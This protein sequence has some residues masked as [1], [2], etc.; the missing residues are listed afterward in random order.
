MGIRGYTSMPSLSEIA[1]RPG[2]IVVD[3]ASPVPILGV[4]TGFACVI[5]EFGKGF[6]YA[7]IPTEVTSAQDR[8]EKFGGWMATLGDQTA[9]GGLSTQYTYNGNGELSLRNKTFSRLAVL[10]VDQHVGHVAISRTLSTYGTIVSTMPAPFVLTPAGQLVLDFD[11]LGAPVTTTF[12]AAAA[13]RECANAEVYNLAFP[14]NEL[15]VKV[16]G[17]AR[18]TL[19][20]A[21]PYFVAPG[22]ATAEEVAAAI[23]D[24]LVGGSA[25]ATTGATKV[26]V[27]SDKKG[28]G[29]YI[30][31]EGGS[32]NAVLAFNTAAVQGTG[33]SNLLDITA[34]SMAE[35]ILVINTAIGV[36][37]LA[38]SD[39]GVYLKVRT[40]TAGGAPNGIINLG[41]GT[42]DMST[43]LG[44]D[45]IQHYGSA[46]GVGTTGT[47]PAGTIVSASISGNRFATL[48][49]VYFATTDATGTGVETGS[50]AIPVR[51]ANAAVYG[52]AVSTA[53]LINTIAA[54]DLDGDG[55][56]EVFTV[57]NAAD[58]TAWNPSVAY[59]TA[60]ATL[61]SRNAPA[62]DINILFSTRHTVPINAQLRAHVATAF[63]QGL[64]RIACISPTQGTTKTVAEGNTPAT[65]GVGVNP[66]E[67]LVY[68]FPGAQTYHEDLGYNVD[69][70]SDSFAASIMSN[71][72]PERSPAEYVP[73]I[74]TGVVD[75][76]SNCRSGGLIGELTSP[77]Y[78]AF[79]AAGIMGL[80][81][82]GGAQFDDGINS[83]AAVDASRKDIER[84][85]MS[86]YMTQS[87]AQ[88]MNFYSKKTRSIVNKDSAFSVIQGFVDGLVSE[89]NVSFQ[90][91][92]AGSVDDVSGNTAA[93]EAAEIHVIEVRGK[94]LGKMR[95][96]VINA[97][98]GNTVV[99]EQA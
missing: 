83:Y 34:V 46:G 90:R 64:F 65:F 15:W 9:I 31:V 99:V 77:D 21:A 62:K 52:G 73:D 26:T 2:V 50:T 47:I 37:G 87:I 68:C 5:G 44:L 35:A 11:A 56:T 27:K 19:T 75:L 28:Y 89:E 53:G 72:A 41:T 1:K 8:I 29:S 4:G 18:Q 3:N 16:D 78:E 48:E 45:L 38:W 96:I 12:N 71:I 55:V 74:L 86:D 59:S 60:I 39:D 70:T 36:N 93:T 97:F 49:D 95:N 13:S 57:T 7:N 42:P 98:I 40:A 32:A 23:N 67:R 54:L 17:G 69:V 10:N 14:A 30:Q 76:E 82:E 94:T 80:T 6:R 61:L 33:S 63:S 51:P 92:A 88:R 66:S 91:L 43:A 58:T 20:L 79:V 24:L 22:A 81:M 25:T 84:T 85:R